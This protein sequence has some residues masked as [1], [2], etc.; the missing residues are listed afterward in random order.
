MIVLTG[1]SSA[2]HANSK[3]MCNNPTSSAV[4]HYVAWV[5]IHVCRGGMPY[6]N[7]MCGNWYAIQALVL[8]EN[9]HVQTFSACMVDGWMDGWTKYSKLAAGT[10]ILIIIPG[11]FRSLN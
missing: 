10:N 8:W 3:T 1:N 11:M 4:V 2:Q 6:S 5:C 9:D 7:S